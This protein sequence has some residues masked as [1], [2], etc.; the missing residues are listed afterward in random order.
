MLKRTIWNKFLFLPTHISQFGINSKIR[1]NSILIRIAQKHLT[2]CG[3]QAA[4]SC[5]E[6][7]FL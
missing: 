5:R 1:Q 3:A 4:E 7:V 6:E 2:A